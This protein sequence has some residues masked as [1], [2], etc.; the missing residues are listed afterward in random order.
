[1]SP[2]DSDDLTEI[3]AEDKDEFVVLRSPDAAEHRANYC[4]LGRFPTRAQAEAFLAK[5]SQ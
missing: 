1:M 3:V 5:R 4:E 2:Y